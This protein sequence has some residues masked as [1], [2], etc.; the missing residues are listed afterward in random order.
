MATTFKLNAKTVK[1]LQTCSP[2][3]KCSGDQKKGDLNP[4]GVCG[5]DFSGDNGKSANYVCNGAKGFQA[6]KAVGLFALM[7]LFSGYLALH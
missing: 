4:E 2:I 3:K 1:L 7:T 5:G 6:N